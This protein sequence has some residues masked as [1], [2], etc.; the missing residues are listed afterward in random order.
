MLLGFTETLP[1][2]GDIPGWRRVTFIIFRS[3][4]ELPLLSANSMRTDNGESDT[5]YAQ[6]NPR[7]WERDFEWAYAYQGIVTPGGKIM[8]GGWADV[9]NW[10][11][12]SSNGPFIFWEVPSL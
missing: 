10:T 12:A 3:Q 8:L 6:W 7:N 9:L 11:D 2:Q 5:G 4:F 1:P